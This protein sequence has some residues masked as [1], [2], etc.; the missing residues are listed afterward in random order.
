MSKM[1]KIHTILVV[2]GN[3]L[4]RD[5][6]RRMLQSEHPG[7]EVVETDRFEAALRLLK[8]HR[9]Q[10][11]ITDIHLRQGSGLSLTEAIAKRFPDTLVVVFTHDDGPEYKDEALRRGADHFFSKTEPDGEAL[12]D[13]IRNP[14]SRADGV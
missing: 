7:L 1:L 12:L 8:T 13:V 4:A 9:P 10:V 3:P 2:D 11:V 5:S 14:T 6:A